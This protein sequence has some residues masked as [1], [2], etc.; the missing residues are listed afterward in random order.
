MKIFI[1]GGGRS[2]YFLT[3]AFSSKGHSVTIVN[4]NRDECIEIAR[5]VKAAVV[6]GDGTD[7]S[8]LEEAAAYEADALVAITPYDHDNLMACQLAR[9]EFHVPRVLAI[10]DD[11]QNC[12][13]FE[14]LGVKVFPVT[15][16]LV[17]IIEQQTAI[18]EITNLT[19]I[20]GGR[21]NVTE[22]ELAGDAPAVGKEIR[23]LELPED[24][25]IA[26]IMRADAPVIPRGATV[27]R[28][29]DRIVVITLPENHAPVVRMLTGENV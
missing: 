28:A 23:N 6:H 26:L 17:S 24:S 29:H 12:E 25:L 27:L 16:M 18:D 7:P 14:L 15:T 2:V 9:I 22:I 11:P 1:V 4:K 10:V 20:G 5:K 19:P 21:A 3:K 13:L 8:V